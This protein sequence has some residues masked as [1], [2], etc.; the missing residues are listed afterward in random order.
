MTNEAS[1]IIEVLENASK[2][3]AEDT[4][5]PGRKMMGQRPVTTLS[6]VTAAPKQE[7]ESKQEEA[8]PREITAFEMN[9]IA[10][11]EVKLSI[12]RQLAAALSGSIADMNAQLAGV[13]RV[14]AS[15]EAALSSSARA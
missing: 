6:T 11:I 4:A 10:D 5:N 7:E 15:F 12:N 8:P 14:I 1:T 3:A 13:N 9:A 2:A